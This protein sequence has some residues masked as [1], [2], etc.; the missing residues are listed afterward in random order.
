MRLGLFLAFALLP[1]GGSAGRSH[2][3]LILQAD[4][5]TS[6]PGLVRTL[7]ERL[8]GLDVDGTV[9]A[10]QDGRLVVDMPRV[11][12]PERVRQFLM[13]NVS[14][15]LRLVRFPE[16]GGGSPSLEAVFQHLGS[17][18]PPELELLEGDI[19]NEEGLPTGKQYYAVERT[20]IVT[21]RDIRSARAS[22]GLYDRP[23]V[24]F[25]LTPEAG[26]AFGRA[27][28]AN[29][30]SGIAIVLDGEVLSAPT[31]RA[32]ITDEGIIE[33]GFSEQ[34]VH[35]LALLLGS[36]P[37][38]ARLRVVD[39]QVSEAVPDRR[40]RLAMTALALFFVLFCAALV[41]LY[42]RGGRP[43]PA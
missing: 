15:E 34:E 7:Q 14:L 17:P 39:Q 4:G 18:L 21:A 11:E 13:R 3:R 24:Q 30:G 26:Q 37:L 1:F 10:G 27:T 5:Q 36:G 33:G 38:P 35:D 28:E 40:F 31:I 23:I 16:G 8:D 22:L 20:R 43:R 6:M 32:R 2:V 19:L 29:I 42:R 9:E 12:D 41:I 25:S